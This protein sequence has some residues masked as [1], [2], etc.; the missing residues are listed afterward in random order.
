MENSKLDPEIK[1]QFE[2][3]PIGV[4]KIITESNWQ[5][6]IRLIVKNNNLRIDQGATIES[7]TF[8]VMLGFDSPDN[9]I[10]NLMNEAGLTQE[11]AQKIENEVAE[12]I[13]E[14]IKEI[15]ITEMQEKN[16]ESPDDSENILTPP[17][18][19][20][21]SS[22]NESRIDDENSLGLESKEEIL[23]E[24]EGEDEERVFEKVEKIEKEEGEGEIKNEIEDENGDSIIADN[25][26]SPTTTEPT[27]QPISKVNETINDPYREPIE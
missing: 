21:T 11:I 23:K 22:L 9:F 6:K 10:Q 18:S 13:F 19:A 16:E 24:I 27:R 26:K 12:T 14:P 15:L 3:L 20:S 25:F 7:E 5:E 8:L 1:D 17:S 2:K 4:Q